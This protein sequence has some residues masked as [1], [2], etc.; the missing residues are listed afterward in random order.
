MY[1]FQMNG[2]ELPRGSTVALGTCVSGSVLDSEPVLHMQNW[3]TPATLRRAPNSC[4]DGG[5]DDDGQVNR[6]P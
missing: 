1:D 4:F 5:S 3:G 6:G 2:R